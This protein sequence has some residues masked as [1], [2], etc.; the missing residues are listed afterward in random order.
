ME[1]PADKKLQN[2]VAEKYQVLEGHNV[3][4]YHHNGSIVHLEHINLAH[5]DKLVDNGFPYLVAKQ[6][7][8]TKEVAKQA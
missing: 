7:P 6:A 3:G 1:K 4:E 5:A 8:K 2:E